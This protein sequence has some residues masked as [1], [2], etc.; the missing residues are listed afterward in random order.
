MPAWWQRS[1]K[2][3]KSSGRAEAAGRRE[4]ADRLI[5]PRAVER[6][7][8]DR[9]Q[10]DMRE[11]QV[12]HVGDQLVGELVIVREAVAVAAPPGAEMDLVDRDRRASGPG[13]RRASVIQSSSC[14]S[15]RG[16][17][18]TARRWPA[19]PRREARAGRPS[20]AG[21]RHRRR[22]S[23]TCRARR[24]DAGQEHLP[25]AGLDAL[26]HRVAAA[27]PA[28]EVA[29]HADAR[30]VRRPD[31]EGDAV[32]AL[33]GDADARRASR[34]AQM[35]ALGQQ[36][37]V[38]LAQLPAESGRDPRLPRVAPP[39]RSEAVGGTRRSRRR[40]AAKKPSAMH[41]RQSSATRL[42]VLA[43]SITRRSAPRAQNTRTESGAR[44]GAM[45]AEHG[46]RIA[47]VARGR[48]PRCWRAAVSAPADAASCVV[49]SC[50]SCWP[51]CRSSR[52]STPRSGMESQSGRL[53]AS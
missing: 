35:G 47:V 43:P 20:A 19:A 41:A 46:E 24:A 1:T 36:M 12:L 4:E 14:Q 45:Q 5:A 17:P 27:V 23:R 11:A 29:D 28:V 31:R 52:S 33:D 21:A 38:D 9:Q 37:D 6:M 16:R 53:A 44:R 51:P 39:R 3:A 18:T 34:R 15:W 48:S 40:S 25:D 2:R 30:G 8:A 13:A 49:V 26:A 32:D 7:L 22:R 42:A 10:L 50:S